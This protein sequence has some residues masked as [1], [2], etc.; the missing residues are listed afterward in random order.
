MEKLLNALTSIQKEQLE[1][2]SHDIEKAKDWRTIIEAEISMD[3]YLT[4]LMHIGQ[5]S[6]SQIQKIQAYYRA[7]DRSDIDEWF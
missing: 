4:A 7:E 5:F 1:V 2:Y 6:Y 3:A